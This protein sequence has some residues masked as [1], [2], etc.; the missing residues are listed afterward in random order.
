V[1]FGAAAFAAVWT[2]FVVGGHVAAADEAVRRMAAA[3]RTPAGIGVA[4]AV[5]YLSSEY[6]T[7]L[8]L[9]LLVLLMRRRGDRRAAS[10]YVVMVATST[11][12]QIGLKHLLDRPRP[13]P[14]LFPYWQAA[15]YPSGH[16]LT[17]LCLAWGLLAHLT[18]L[19]PTGSGRRWWQ[20][21]AVFLLG[22]PLLVA[23]SRV[24]LDA[25]WTSDVLGGLAL[26]AMHYY[27]AAWLAARHS[28]LAGLRIGSGQGH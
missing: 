8:L 27:G 21:C 15:G 2:L 19:P 14:P 10:S 6:L 17:A 22:W 9:V 23:S 18:R 3:V 25:H 11:L 28:R 7:P 13:Q 4:L 5:S 26:G 20:A 12:W 16:T 1:A 24:Y